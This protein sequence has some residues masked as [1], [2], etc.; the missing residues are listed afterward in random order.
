MILEEMARSLYGYYLEANICQGFSQT[1]LLQNRIL[2]LKNLQSEG[3]EKAL[4]QFQLITDLLEQNGELERDIK[5]PKVDDKQ[6]K[7]NTIT[8]FK[9]RM[10]WKWPRFRRGLQYLKNGLHPNVD[11]VHHLNITQGLVQRVKSKAAGFFIVYNPVV[12]RYWDVNR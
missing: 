1:F 8:L 12:V 4:A 9:P 2:E 5:R 3:H 11:Y 7:N 10:R 6:P